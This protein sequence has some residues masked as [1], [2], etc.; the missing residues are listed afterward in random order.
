MEKFPHAPC[1]DFVTFISSKNENYSLYI[2]GVVL[3]AMWQQN[4]SRPGVCEAATSVRQ[5]RARKKKEKIEGAHEAQG[6]T[7]LVNCIITLKTK[8]KCRH[9]INV[10]VRQCVQAWRF[11]CTHTVRWFHEHSLHRCVQSSGNFQFRFRLSR[12]SDR[13]IFVAEKLHHPRTT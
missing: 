9:E 4:E 5:Q 10:T 8:S 2:F 13:V 12:P 1:I 3:F 11:L 7:A 6:E